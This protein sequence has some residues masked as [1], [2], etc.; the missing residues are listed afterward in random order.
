MVR[1]LPLERQ[2]DMLLER[3]SREL[4]H[5]PPAAR[6]EEVESAEASADDE[7]A[8]PVLHPFVRRQSSHGQSEALEARRRADTAMEAADAASAEAAAKAAHAAE[9]HGTDTSSLSP[10][11]AWAAAKAP[12]EAAY[13]AKR[14]SA[15]REA[16]ESASHDARWADLSSLAHHENENVREYS[17]ASVEKLSS[18]ASF[19]KDE[20]VAARRQSDVI[21]A[22]LALPGEKELSSS[23]RARAVAVAPPPPLAERM[24]FTSDLVPMS[25]AAP[26]GAAALSPFRRGRER[27]RLNAGGSP[28]VRSRA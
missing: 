12:R 15:A 20:R 25:L 24:R 22:A 28:V 7:P 8:S 9:V 21:G 13:A 14:A 10:K 17:R 1:R 19:V 3:A 2:C 18:L 5:S 26:A 4:E 27:W 6:A 16:A 23:R 11:A